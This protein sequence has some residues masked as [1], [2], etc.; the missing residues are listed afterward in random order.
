MQAKWGEMFGVKEDVVE[1][2]KV[3]K[4]RKKSVKKHALLK[5]VIA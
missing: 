2:V 4:P 3:K 5:K 1:D